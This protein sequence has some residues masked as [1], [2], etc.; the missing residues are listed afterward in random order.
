MNGND[1]IKEIIAL[2]MKHRQD[3]GSYS[4]QGSCSHV[5]RTYLLFENITFHV[6]CP[7]NYKTARHLTLLF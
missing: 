2:K 5:D 4:I 7:I 1:V 6:H 3:I